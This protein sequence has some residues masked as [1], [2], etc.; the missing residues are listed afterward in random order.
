MEDE[1]KKGTIKRKE[2]EERRGNQT[3]GT[4]GQ[5]YEADDESCWKSKG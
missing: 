2:V 4:S 3:K 5:G 1:G